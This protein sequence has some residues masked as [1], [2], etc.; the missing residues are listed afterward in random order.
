MK[1][2]FTL[3]GMKYR[4]TERDV[5]ALKDGDLLRLVR[6]KNNQHDRNAVSVWRGDKMLA[7]IKGT[8]AVSLARTMDAA[9]SVEITGLFRVTSDRWPQVEVDR[10]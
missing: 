1:D 9:R 8:E 6:E 7:Y 3:V 10:R 4:G 5:A 2:I